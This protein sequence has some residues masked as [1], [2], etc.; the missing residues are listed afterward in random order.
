MEMCRKYSYGFT[1]CLTN[2]DNAIVAANV[3]SC[4]IFVGKAW[5][6]FFTLCLSFLLV[7][8]IQLFIGLISLCVCDNCCTVYGPT[9][10]LLGQK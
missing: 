8:D 6:V 7:V 3:S 1:Q 4:R 5:L 10:L 9:A 2:S